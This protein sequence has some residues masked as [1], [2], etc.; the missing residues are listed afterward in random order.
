MPSA[1]EQRSNVLSTFVKQAYRL[2]MYEHGT[3][4]LPEQQ[5]L[6]RRLTIAQAFALLLHV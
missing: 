5:G 2:R 3:L 1:I 4:V 6:A